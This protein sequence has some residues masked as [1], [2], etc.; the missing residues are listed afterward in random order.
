MPD[1]KEWTLRFATPEDGETLVEMVKLLLVHVGDG[2]DNFNEQRFLEDAFGNDP[3]FSVLVAVNQEGE[4]GGYALFHDSYEPSHSARGVY[5]VDLFVKE[6]A[7]GK[8]VGKQLIAGVAR[9]ARRRGREFIWLVSPGED[10]R[11]FYGSTM[12]IKVEVV[13]YALTGEDF[14]GLAD[15]EML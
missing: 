2:T 6:G 4:L 15:L 3:Q 14:E 7:R 5:L 11:A 13:A 9:D 10:A 8:G 12:N 1:I